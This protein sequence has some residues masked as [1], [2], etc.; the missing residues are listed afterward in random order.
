[1]LTACLALG[2]LACPAQAGSA[3]FIGELM[4][5]GGSFCP[6]NWAE[7]D[8]REIPIAQ[9]P[10]LFSLFGTNYGGDGRNNFGLPKIAPPAGASS[11]RWC[12][13]LEGTFPPR[14]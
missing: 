7:A 4:L 8:G 5:F 6:R 9:N 11:A 2:T 1:M 3:P 12:V 14:N 10:A 13:S